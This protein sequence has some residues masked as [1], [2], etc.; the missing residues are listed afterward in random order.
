[1]S[2]LETID[3][4]ILTKLTG[5]TSGLLPPTL[6]LTGLEYGAVFKDKAPQA[7]FCFSNMISRVILSSI[8]GNLSK[9]VNYL[10]YINLK[11]GSL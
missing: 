8:T 1:M 7:P 2:G 3:K 5:N 11:W 4:K 10:I 6:D 9:D